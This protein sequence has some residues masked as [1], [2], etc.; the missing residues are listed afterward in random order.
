MSY[1]ISIVISSIRV[2]L[3]EDLYA[4]I[5]TSFHGSWELV[6]VGPYDIS[7]ELMNKGNVKYIKDF[8]SPTRCWNIGVLNSAGNYIHLSCDDATYYPNVLDECFSSLDKDNYKYMVLTK[9]LEGDSEDGN[10]HMK[11]D[12]YYHLKE[13]ALIRNIIERMGKDYLLL[14]NFI[15][16][17]KLLLELGVLDCEYEAFSMALVDFSIR[18]FNYGAEIVIHPNPVFK[19]TFLWGD[20]GDHGPVNKAHNDHDIP[21]FFTTYAYHHNFNRTKVDI[22]NWEKSPEK[23]QR[24]F[25]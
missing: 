15:I 12:A 17:K 4:S 1:D 22:N 10:E 23:W 11:K 9:Y 3:L 13:H 16:S 14:N 21:L 5:S 19:V 6:I 2:N 8:G 7:E 24:R 25:K 20:A 18:T